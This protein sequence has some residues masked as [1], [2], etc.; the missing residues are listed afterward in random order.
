M[1]FRHQAEAQS[2]V[3]SASKPGEIISSFEDEASLLDGSSNLTN[4]LHSPNSPGTEG[5]SANKL[6]APEKTGGG[7]SYTQASASSLDIM[8]SIYS[9]GG[10]SGL[11]DYCLP[12]FDSMG[13]GYGQTLSFPVQLTNS[14]I[15][16]TDPMAHA[17]SDEDHLQFFDTDIQSQC[18]IEADLQSAVDGFMLARTSNAI[19]KAQRRWRKLFNVL[20]W[21]MVRKR[22]R[23]G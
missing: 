6:L 4:V 10:T 3:I 14:L 12:N 8:S 2:S 16:D 17:F 21:F 15:C 22:E 9:V 18:H 1:N 5:S 20:K 23:Y 11:D 13:L 7:F 19:G